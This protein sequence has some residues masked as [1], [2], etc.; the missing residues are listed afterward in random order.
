[1]QKFKAK[2]PTAKLNSPAKPQWMRPAPLPT[3]HQTR[4]QPLKQARHK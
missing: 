3:N 2:M 4:S 1:L